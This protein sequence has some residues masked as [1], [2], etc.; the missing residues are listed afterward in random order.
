MNLKLLLL[1]LFQYEFL[2]Y[3]FSLFHDFVITTVE[4]NV[5]FTRYYRKDDPPAKEF[6]K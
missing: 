4:I 1:Q 2:S 3:H 5:N 6:S